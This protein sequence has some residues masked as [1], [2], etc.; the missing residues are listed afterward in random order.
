MNSLK[1]V[2]AELKKNN[3]I[4]E[5]KKVIKV[6]AEEQ[7]YYQVIVHLDREK[8][9]TDFPEGLEGFFRADKDTQSAF[10]FKLPW[11][12]DKK[13]NIYSEKPSDKLYDR[14][15]EIQKDNKTYYMLINDNLGYTNLSRI[16]PK[17]D[18]EKLGIEWSEEDNRYFT[19]EE[20]NIH[21]HFKNR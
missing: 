3:L 15:Y 7:T 11:T 17:D 9:F 5:A 2:I 19:D 10:L 20:Y 12:V 16:V 14:V 18:Y 4:A 8:D 6:I 21:E 1:D 13:E